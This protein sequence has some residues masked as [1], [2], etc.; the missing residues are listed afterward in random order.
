ML[1]FIAFF[2]VWLGVLGG[3]FY[4]LVGLCCGSGNCCIFAVTILRD[5]S[6][7]HEWR[8]KNRYSCAFFIEQQQL[9]VIVYPDLCNLFDPM[10]GNYV[11]LELFSC[12]HC[13]YLQINFRMSTNC[14]TFAVE[15][16]FS[17]LS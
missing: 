15:K 7:V 4:F 11:F 5:L 9:S 14:C 17:K 6:P 3:F 12:S 1:C 13:N 8:P 16:Q 10:I 2:V